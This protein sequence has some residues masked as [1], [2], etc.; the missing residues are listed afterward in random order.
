MR[1]GNNLYLINNCGLFL[2]LSKNQNKPLINNMKYN[3]TKYSNKNISKIFF[4]KS[5]KN[6]FPKNPETNNNTESNEKPERSLKQIDF[7]SKMTKE[8]LLHN[9]CLNNKI[10]FVE[11]IKAWEKYGVKEN[12]YSCILFDE[13]TKFEINEK[14]FTFDEK[15]NKL[16]LENIKYKIKKIGEDKNIGS[17]VF[18]SLFFNKEFDKM[19]SISVGNILYSILRETSRQNYEIIYIST[20]QYHDINI[21][22]QLSSF[23][24]D[25]KYLGISYHNININDI[26]IIGNNKQNILSYINEINSKNDKDNSNNI[27]DIQINDFNNYLA[28]YKIIN[29]Q[30][31]VLNSDNLS[32]NST[33]S[34]C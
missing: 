13:M 17:A 27:E 33:S 14:F 30:I 28:K 21:P 29:G 25:Y 34:S 3:I 10:I 20:G 11:G 2:L 7:F 24:D 19:I 32:N 5:L 4:E 8:N 16:L 31:N 15:L 1:K 6:E 12:N 18:C 9:I 22:Y 23:N 26:I